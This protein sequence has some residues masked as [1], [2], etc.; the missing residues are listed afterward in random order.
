MEVLRKP[1]GMYLVGV[2][3]V[4][5]VFFI[6]NPFLIDSLDVPLIWTILDILIVIALVPALL[7]NYMRKSQQDGQDSGGS[8]TRSYLEANV[9]FFLTAAVAILFLHNWFSQ[10]SEGVQSSAASNHVA[11]TIWAVVDTMLPLVIG[12]TGCKMWC[13]AG[14]D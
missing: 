9:A 6:I 4:V 3:T 11:W 8:I 10:L 14:K 13:G 12:A 5:A 1:A 7:F 2:A